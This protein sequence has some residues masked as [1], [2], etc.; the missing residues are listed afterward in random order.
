MKNKFILILSAVATPTPTLIRAATTQIQWPP[1]PMGTQLTTATKFHQFISYIYEWGISLGGIAVFVMLL[2]AGVEYL[3]SAGDPGKMR[4]AIKR[5][6]SSILGLILL[7]TS[8]LILNTINPQLVRLAPLPSDPW[9]IKKP[10]PVHRVGP[11]KAQV[12]PCDFVVVW[13]KIGQV[14]DPSKPI[15]FAENE[16][17]IVIEGG[18]IKNIANPWMSAKNFIR[19]TESELRM[20][21]K[22]P[23]AIQRYNHLGVSDPRY[24]PYKVGGFCNIDFFHPTAELGICGENMGRATLPSDDFRLSRTDHE[25]IT[26]I[27]IVRSI[28]RVHIPARLEFPRMPNGNGFQE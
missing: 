3:T 20:L 23:Y 11:A 1:S 7:L 16:E 15:R 10:L 12:P 28:K 25:R 21:E 13:S 4:D 2:W 27:Q 14:S 5:I 18:G 22:E 24:G 9:G 19:L 26:C 17:V 6:K 8:W